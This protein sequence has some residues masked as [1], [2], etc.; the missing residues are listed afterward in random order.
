MNGSCS[1]QPTPP[2]QQRGI[3]TVSVTYAA[4]HG[5]TGSF[6][7][8]AR[9]RIEPASSWMLVRFMSAKPRGNLTHFNRR[10]KR[11]RVGSLGGD[12]LRGRPRLRYRTCFG[13]LNWVPAV[14][15]RE[16]EGSRCCKIHL[17]E[18]F[19]RLLVIWGKNTRFSCPTEILV[20]LKAERVCLLHLSVSGIL[21]SAC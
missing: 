21:P 11:V 12:T 19:W 4:A 14:L 16:L 17:C 5:H 6:T 15:A 10:T 1:C 9:P 8:G 13:L 2:P 18:A 20:W 3:R 7:H